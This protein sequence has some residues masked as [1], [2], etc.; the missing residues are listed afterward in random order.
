MKLRTLLITGA[1]I[2]TAGGSAVAQNTLSPADPARPGLQGDDSS[3]PNGLQNNTG[4][5]LP[6]GGEPVKHTPGATIGAGEAESAT[7]HFSPG[8]GTDP[9]HQTSD[10]NTSPASP[11]A[12]IKQIK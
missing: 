6:A 2:I 12:G 4:T 3:K 7:S 9:A 5:G 10:K 8:P 1:F 11:N